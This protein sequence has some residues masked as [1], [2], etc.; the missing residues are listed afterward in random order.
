MVGA[1]IVRKLQSEGYNDIITRTHSELDLTDQA[2][3]RDFFKTHKI[4][5][6]VLAAAKVGGIHANNTY[7]AE[8]IYQNLMIQSNV[9]HEAYKA[10]VQH[11]L[12]LGSSCIYPK[13]CPQ[14][15]KEEYLLSGYLE[16]TNEPYAIAKIAGIKMCESYNRQYGTKY[17]SVMPTNL[18]GP[19]DNYH[20]ENSHVIPAIIRKYHL[21]KLAM[22]GNLEAIQKDEQTYGPIPQDIK[23]AIGLAEDSSALNS[24]GSCSPNPSVLGPGSSLSPK[25]VLWGSGKAKREFLHVDDMAAAC[26]DVMQLLPQSLN[27]CSCSKSPKS[28][29]LSPSSSS[30]S[31]YNVGTGKDIT[32]KEVAQVI[33]EIVGFKGETIY[34]SDKPDGTPQKL[35]DTTMIN[36]I[37]W[38]PAFSLKVGLRDAYNWYLK[39]GLVK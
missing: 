38:E 6:V 33:C 29:N 14:P 16:P 30:P 12:F 9:I 22:E 39:S 32:I 26:Y 31:F 17:R 27:T 15:M 10:G 5:Y 7:P 36:N 34:D 21:A 13:M 28:S 37:G 1:A 25:V 23:Q 2:A 4:D 11:L 35:L 24:F 8:F 20:L 3:V 19:G 18:Y